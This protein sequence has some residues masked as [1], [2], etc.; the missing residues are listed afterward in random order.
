MEIKKEG[1]GDGKI[2]QADK[3][4]ADIYTIDNLSL[5]GR[6]LWVDPF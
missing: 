1:Q 6:I 2:L 5:H 3:S 4:I